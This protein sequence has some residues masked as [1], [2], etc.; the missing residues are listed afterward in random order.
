MGGTSFDVALIA[1]GRSVLSP[2]TTID[3]GMVVRTPMIE[4]T[5]IG[6][7]GGSIA[8]VD[9]GGLL[10]IGPESAGSD[11]GPA[12]YG[13]GQ[14]RPTV[15][16]ANVVL[17]RI[18][19][20]RPIGGK[21]KRLDVEAARRAIEAQVATP[22][23][24]DLMAAAEAI[25]RVANSRMAGAIRLVSIERGHD[26]K[27]FALMPFGGAG[28]LHAGA[29][30]KEVGLASTLVPRYPGVTSALGCV[31][32]DMRHDFVQTINR[33]L[34][35]LDIDG[36]NAAIGEMTGN[37]R[38][39]LDRAGIKLGGHE[40]S[41][42]LD[43]S[44]IGQTHTVSVP[45]DIARGALTVR[46]IREAFD[47][48]YRAAFGRLLDGIPVR[49]LTLRAAVIGQRPKFD[50][51]ILAPGAGST[52]PIGERTVWFDGKA[53]ATRIYDRLSLPI[54]TEIPGPAILEQPDAT[55]WIDPD[56]TGRVDRFGNLILTRRQ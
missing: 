13:K 47:A 11:P 24:L 30:M 7:G 52:A 48:A 36:L 39:L 40:A 43:M 3:F 44:Y 10:Q 5:T 28:A 21:L 9:A 33:P 31:I 49:V 8:W 51:A 18:N 17:G 35:A 25:V 26:P 56:L 29:L 34:D 20:D 27:R 42:E 6:A 46:A 16:D 32:A 23:G 50:L 1:D 41:V 19:P 55:T 53:H 22:L 37:G 38:A 45:V 14:T 4:I 54:G 12:A 2:Q 15:T